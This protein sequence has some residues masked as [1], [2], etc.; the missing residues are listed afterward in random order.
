MNET[1]H[2]GMISI[3]GLS[4]GALVLMMARERETRLSLWE[5]KVRRRERE[6]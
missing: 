5:E 6:G 1:V 2:D 4:N 3:D